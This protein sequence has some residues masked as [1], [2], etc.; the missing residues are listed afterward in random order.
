MNDKIGQLK[1]AIG[2]PTSQR[3]ISIGLSMSGADS[4]LIK[5]SLREAVNKKEALQADHYYICTD[6]FGSI[7]AA[8]GA[9][10]GGIV[11]IA[12]TGSN[13]ALVNADGSS[14]NCGG[15]G[16]LFGDEGSGYDI[17]ATAIRLIFEISD[18]YVACPAGSIDLLRQ[19]MFEYFKVQTPS[20]SLKDMLN[21]FYRDFKKDF[22]AGFALC[23]VGAANEGDEFA[24]YVMSIIGERLGRHIVGVSP[25][26][27]DDGTG[28]LSVICVGSVWK[29]FALFKD[30]FL[31]VTSTLNR[32]LELVK[33]KA[34]VPIAVGAAALGAQDAPV[35][36]AFDFA[37]H[38]EV[39]YNSAA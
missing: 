36:P 29:S 4:D 8:Y 24:N 30:S 11:L 20:P 31:R 15:W 10:K 22:F 28:P 16:H 32:P 33:I 34:E 6:T 13:C 2:V 25:S 37:N 3:L 38:V 7:A 21:H 14:A 18:R 12:G 17:A 26:V 19:K 9:K 35:Q 39:L 1:T 23:V 5:A 27:K